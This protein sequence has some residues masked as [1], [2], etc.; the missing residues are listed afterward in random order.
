MLVEDLSSFSDFTLTIKIVPLPLE[1]LKFSAKKQENNVILQWETVSEKD[2]D[3][4]LVERYVRNN[5]RNN[6]NNSNNP[7]FDFVNIG[8]VASKSANT[9][10][11]NTTQNSNYY[12]FIDVLEDFNNANFD[13]ISSS[14]DLYYR[15]KMVD[16]NGIFRYSNV[17]FVN[18]NNSIKNAVVIYPN[19]IQNEE[20]NIHFAEN[21]TKNSNIENI[22]ISILSILGHEIYKVTI[23]SSEKNIKISTKN[24]AKGIYFAKILIDNH[25]IIKKIEI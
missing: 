3:Y 4:F 2:F 24:W 22:D 8:R 15:L 1:I 23:S 11:Q 7:T 19:P 6:N 10:Q 5:N 25:L 9:N 12:S 18:I 14:K 21:N 17:R 13:D 16:K 20:I